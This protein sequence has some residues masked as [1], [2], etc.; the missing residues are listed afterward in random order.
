MTL[1][2]TEA[3]A[4]RLA[5]PEILAGLDDAAASI[6]A[7]TWLFTCNALRDKWLRRPLPAEFVCELLADYREFSFRDGSYPCWWDCG[8]PGYREARIAHL[9]A[10]R[11]HLQESCE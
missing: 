5:L 1:F 4:R 2:H 11:S 3:G 7:G 9:N 10:F 8:S 6:R